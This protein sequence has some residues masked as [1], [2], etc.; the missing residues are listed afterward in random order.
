MK[1]GDEQRMEVALQH[2]SAGQALSLAK[3][4]SGLTNEEI[5]AALGLNAAVVQRWFNPHD[6]YWPSLPNIPALCRT[7]G[8]CII[9]DWLAAQLQDQLECDGIN[10]NGLALAVAS[11]ADR[12]GRVA[13]AVVESVSD[14]DLTPAE[15]S[16]IAGKIEALERSIKPVKD[17]ISA[18]VRAGGRGQ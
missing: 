17:G 14:G 5:A 11:V 12:M 2:V 16:R 7:L 1:N 3:D 6:A 10:V 4:K 9:A 18:L 13:G 15:A 8:N